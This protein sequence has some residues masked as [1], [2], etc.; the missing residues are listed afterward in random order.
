ML[1]RSKQPKCVTASPR[2][3]IHLIN[4]DRSPRRLDTFEAVNSHIMP[5][6]ERFSAIDGA[7]VERAPLVERGIITADLP[8]NDG[9]LGNALSHIA[10]WD[11]AIEQDR[12][13]T[14]CEDDAIFN[15]S[16][17]EASETVLRELPSDWHVILWGWN[18]DS[19]LWFS[20]IPG[21]S[22]CTS[23]FDQG[24][25]QNGI[26]TYQSA[27]VRP[28]PFKLFQAFGTVCYSVS[29]T[30]ARLLRQYCL[31]LR[32][33]VVYAPGLK[34]FVLNY[35]IDVTLNGAYG[36]LN[37]FVSFPPLVVTR[38]DRKLSTIQPNLISAS[39]SPL[40]RLLR[41]AARVRRKLSQTI[42][43]SGNFP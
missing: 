30:G 8:Y 20:L 6:V 19:L 17:S 7:H 27:S 3:K 18:F 32:N 33:N 14:I 28:R 42:G 25:L 10:L 11:M 43:R 39:S 4:L 41:S 34:A 13:L 23:R 5:S 15:R 12:S 26:D 9:S 31:P 1:E 36:Y 35:G 16:F 24:S 37:S 38:N 21:V 40:S 29:S 22:D 2:L